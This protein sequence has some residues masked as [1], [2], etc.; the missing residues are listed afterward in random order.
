MLVRKDM[1]S[2]IN[3][4]DA[5]HLAVKRPLSSL[6]D[7]MAKK[8]K[9]DEQE[10]DAVDENLLDIQPIS[11]QHGIAKGSGPATTNGGLPSKVVARNSKLLCSVTLWVYGLQF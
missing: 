7:G 1:K 9:C 11:E 10:G 5:H 2:T 6:S 4:F 3:P 8:Q